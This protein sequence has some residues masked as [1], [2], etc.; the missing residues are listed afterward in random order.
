MHLD[1]SASNAEFELLTKLGIRPCYTRWDAKA[2]KYFKENWAPP[3]SAHLLSLLDNIPVDET[4]NEMVLSTIN[5]WIDGTDS[6][7]DAILGILEL[8]TDGFGNS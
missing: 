7:R 6:D 1:R 4:Y 3:S 8:R 2:R 5:Q